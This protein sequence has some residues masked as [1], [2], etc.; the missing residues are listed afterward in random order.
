M[1]AKEGI[2]YLLEHCKMDEPIFIL[3][4]RDKIAPDAIFAWAHLA[5][6]NGVSED[7]VCSAIAVAAAMR[8]WP[9]TRFPD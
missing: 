6:K 4:G 9:N 1:T 3:R 7:K 8:A 2:K 5:E